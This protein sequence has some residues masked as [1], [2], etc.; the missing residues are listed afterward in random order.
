[1]KKS[2]FIFTCVFLLIIDS[3]CQ[4]C[5][6]SRRRAKKAELLTEQKDEV[7]D[8]ERLKNSTS[9]PAESNRKESSSTSSINGDT[10]SNDKTI[11]QMFPIL[12]K[13]VFMVYSANDYEGGQGSGFFITESGIGITNYHVMAGH[14]QHVI[15]LSN[16]EFYEISEVLSANEEA[17]YVIFRVQGGAFPFLKVADKIPS[18]GDDVFAIGSPKG[19]ENSLTKGSISQ[20]REDGDT[21]LLQIDAT[22]D[23][24]SSGGALFNMNGEVIGITSS[25]HEGSNLNFAIDISEVP[26]RNYLN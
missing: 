25:G 26:Y 9:K 11:S 12:E 3:G 6:R 15:K 16:D 20:F 2:L 18:V 13:A 8:V 4:S 21:R 7:K 1:M 5:S 24:G 23:H 17:D 14:D 22:I 10:G 19:L